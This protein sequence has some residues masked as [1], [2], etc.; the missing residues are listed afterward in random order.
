MRLRII[1]GS[2]GGRFIDAPPGRSTRPTPARVRE[3]WFAAAQPDLAGAPVIDLFAGSGALG[4]EALSRG[5]AHAHF[6]EK[7]RLA[8]ATIR[9]NLE[10]LG[11]T[12]RATVLRADV[13][14]FLEETLGAPWDVALADPPYAGGHA[15]RLVDRFRERPFAATL[16]VEHEAR[17]GGLDGADWSRTY[18]DTRLS[19]FRARNEPVEPN[20]TDG[21]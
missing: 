1:A 12:G 7:D 21:E 11:L 14:R 5:A 13:W 20:L 2:R 8:I 4:I 3:A 9:D 15:R 10:A 18:G 19:R 17:G 6:V 16:W